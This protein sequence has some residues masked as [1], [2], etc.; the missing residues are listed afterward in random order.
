MKVLFLCRSESQVIGLGEIRRNLCFG[1]VFPVGKS[2]KM[3]FKFFLNFDKNRNTFRVYLPFKKG[4][5][6]L[7]FII[8]PG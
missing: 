2:I 8:K 4:I 6:N 1:L 5:K 7:S 3:L